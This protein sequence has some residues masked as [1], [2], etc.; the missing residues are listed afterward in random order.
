MKRDRERKDRDRMI[1][2]NRGQRETE[3]RGRQSYREIQ[4]QREI[5]RDRRDRIGEGIWEGEKTE[6]LVQIE[7]ERGRETKKE[8]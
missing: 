8:T 1:Q 7:M 5:Q 2:R 4:R 3:Q 6:I